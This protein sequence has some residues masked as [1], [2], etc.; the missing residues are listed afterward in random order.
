MSTFSPFF[1]S[2]LAEVITGGSGNDAAQPIGIYRSGPKIQQFFLDC[3]INM[4]VGNSSHDR[5]DPRR[6]S[7]S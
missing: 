2:A 7:R 3:G 5:S 6:L 4:S 1:I